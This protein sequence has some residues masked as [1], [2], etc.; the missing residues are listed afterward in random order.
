MPQGDGGRYNGNGL[1]LLFWKP[2]SRLLLV[3]RLRGSWNRNC[4]AHVFNPSPLC[5][6]IPVGATVFTDGLCGGFPT[7]S[8]VPISISS[9]F[10]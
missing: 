10:H 3:G 9:E 2:V 8:E 5:R 7:T 4:S 1:G 6:A